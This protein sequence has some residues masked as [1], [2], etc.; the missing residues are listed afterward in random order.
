MISKKKI[1]ISAPFLMLFFIIVGCIISG[2][3]VQIQFGLNAQYSIFIIFEFIKIN[4][5]NVIIIEGICILCLFILIPLFFILLLLFSK[6]PFHLHGNAS[7]ITDKELGES[8]L[9]K[10]GTK[11][12][13]LFIGRVANGKYKG[14]LIRA[15]GNAPVSLIAGT[16]EGK[17]VSFAIPNMLAYTDSVVVL[18]PKGELYEKTAGYRRSVGHKIFL[19]SPDSFAFNEE[20][21][22]NNKVYSDVWNVFDT[23]RNNDLF[24][25]ND[26]NQIGL[27]FFPFTPDEIWNDS[28]LSLFVTVGNYIFDRYNSVGNSG[29]KN[30]EFYPSIPLMLKIQAEKGDFK[31]YFDEVLGEVE[32]GTLTLSETTIRG[33]RKYVNNA[34]KTRQSIDTTFNSALNMFNNPMCAFTTSGKSTFNFNRCRA[35]KISIYFVINPN[36]M[37]A[38]KRLINL[39]FSKLIEQNMDFLPEKNPVYK[40]QLLVMLDEFATLGEVSIIAESITHISGYNIRLALIFQDV[41]QLEDEDVYGKNKTHTI[42]S[43]C[44]VEINFPPISINDEA[45]RLSKAIGDI[46]YKLKDCSRSSSRGGGSTTRSVK[47]EKRALYLPQEIVALGKE[48]Y[49][50]AK[51]GTGLK[52]IFSKKIRTELGVKEIIFKK[53]TS[54]IICD[55]IIYF[56]DEF[57]STR[58]KFSELQ[59]Q[60][61]G[62]QANDSNVNHNI[63]MPTLISV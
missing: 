19:F 14:R 38:Y 4:P 49:Y 28:A 23:V 30:D 35:E 16:R 27:N 45:E 25:D 17:G 42:L 12:P 9:L 51:K 15:S 21:L 29:I 60:L 61:M 1:L 10:K 43:S 56:D 11:Y 7:L 33:I 52:K 44:E 24:R 39:F 37:D 31:K 20:S 34:D 48:V 59:F 57:F 62:E 58:A 26:L 32:R 5:R 55:K 3:F 36:N 54:P 8:T 18:D 46:T 50:L 13:D 6:K 47:L 41:N 40:Y 22:K 63:E 2:L 53:R